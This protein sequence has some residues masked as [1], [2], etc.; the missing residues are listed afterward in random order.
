MSHVTFPSILER[1]EAGELG[2][3]GVRAAFDAM[4]DGAWSSVQIASFATA[5]RLRGEDEDTLVAAASALRAAMSRVDHGLSAVLDTCGT[6]GDGAGTVNVST[7]AAVLVASLGVPVAKHGNRSVSS[8]SGSADVLEALGLPLDVPPERQA[9]ILAEVG[10]AFLLA[11]LHH[12]ALRHASQARR[13]LGIRTIFNAL[14]PLANPARATHQLLGV[15][16]DAIRGRMARALARLGVRRAWVVRSEDG[17]DELSPSAP[18]RVS[19]LGEDGAVVERVVQPEDFGL[20]RAPLS[21]LAGG[22]PGENALALA[23]LFRGEPHPATP[24]VLL[25]AAAAL[26]VATGEPLPEAASRVGEAHREGRAAT[27]FHA[28]KRAAEASR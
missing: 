5:L 9:G 1:L 4:L 28:W 11:P 10:I 18:T 19:A 17:L 16:D 14:G 22:D 13:E 27:L 7:A 20:P 6:G 25:N 15:Y 24:A 12:P 8:R 21:S 23:T 26:H 3:E 2:P